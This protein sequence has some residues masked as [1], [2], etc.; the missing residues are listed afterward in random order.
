ML[1]VTATLREAARLMVIAGLTSL[2]Y[3]EVRRARVISA[4][5][6]ILMVSFTKDKSLDM[7]VDGPLEGFLGPISWSFSH[8]RTDVLDFCFT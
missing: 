8:A 4:S 7:H 1:R 3:K 5:Q 6:L 2:R